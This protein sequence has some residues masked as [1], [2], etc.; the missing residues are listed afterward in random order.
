MF[1]SSPLFFT[2]PASGPADWPRFLLLARLMLENLVSV[3]WLVLN[4]FFNAGCFVFAK[5]SPD[6]I[7]YA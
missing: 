3:F 5:P 4:F 7:N 6:N 1:F 2:L